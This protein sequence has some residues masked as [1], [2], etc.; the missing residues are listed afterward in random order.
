VTS[1]WATPTQASSHDDL[2][3]L[4]RTSTAGVSVENEDS[5]TTASGMAR[6]SMEL[7]EE[8]FELVGDRLE[9]EVEGSF[10]NQASSEIYT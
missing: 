4:E 2:R 8:E 9:D 5:A 3:T 1:A 10:W 7:D 6:S